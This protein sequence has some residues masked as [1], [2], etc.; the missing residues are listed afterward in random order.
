MPKKD[1][2]NKT[3]KNGDA[4]LNPFA[5]SLLSG[6]PVVKRMNSSKKKNNQK[7]GDNKTL[8]TVQVD[9]PPVVM[10]PNV[11]EPKPEVLDRKNA[12]ESKPVEDTVD[13]DDKS[14]DE[15][16]LG[17]TNEIMAEEEKNA[18]G[19]DTGFDEKVDEVEQTESVDKV[20]SVDQDEPVELAEDINENQVSSV[21]DSSEPEPE[22]EPGPEPEP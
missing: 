1:K 22:S 13:V 21:S 3:G 4:A 16:L 19:S 20:E 8:K 18:Y 11:V 7:R 14:F 9:Q 5:K 2:N 15:L 12:E 6:K 10:A 17:D